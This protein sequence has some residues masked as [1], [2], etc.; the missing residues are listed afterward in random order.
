[1]QTTNDTDNRQQGLQ[2]QSYLGNK[3][4]VA[5]LGLLSAFVPLSTD[6]YLP[7][8]PTI[9]NYFQVHQSLANLT[10]LLFFISF[11]IGTLF[12]GPMSDKYGR[13]PVLLAGL[14][15][16]TA[17]SVFCAVSLTINQLILS[18]ALQAFG[19]S[20]ATAVA[21]AIVK[22]VYSGRKRESVLGLVQSMVV[23]CPAVAPVIGAFLLMFTSWKGVFLV[24]AAIGLVAVAGAFALQETL[25]E[26]STG[27]VLHTIGRLGAVLKNP[28]FTSLLIVFSLPGI[29]ALS[30]IAGSTYIYQ[31]SFGLS[32]Q[33]YSY[34]FAF[35][36]I[37]M[38]LGPLL[39]LRLSTYFKRNMIINSGFVV[40]ILSGLLI[41]LFGDYSPWLFAVVLLPAT[42]ITSA[43]R[44]PSTYLMME[45]QNGDTG[46]VSS[47][48]NCF[49][50]A[51][52]SIGILIVSFDWSNLMAVV[53]ALHL[54]L[55]LVC[56]GAWLYISRQDFLNQ[57]CEEAV[58]KDGE[59]L[60]A[61]D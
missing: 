15:I 47:L 51:L 7:A 50:I 3:G 32:S 27:T 38:L 56:G 36:A 24:Q 4:L 22:D 37:G 11:G 14:I 39:Y 23:I 55:G 57:A 49:G 54:I 29:A 58:D 30:F 41:C 46:S 5:L 40:M 26:K 19:G 60:T 43:L 16:Y 25:A 17:A 13:K 20:A 1:M 44:P 48:I 10:L 31:N 18:R 2:P 6:I 45:Q 59:A 9:A 34:Y 8:L 12:W 35:N 28:R 53:G 21:T 42:I 61:N 52:G 33:V